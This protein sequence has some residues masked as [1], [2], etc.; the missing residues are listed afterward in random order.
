M[1]INT[2]D[3]AGSDV[4][5]GVFGMHTDDLG[6]TWTEPQEITAELDSGEVLKFPEPVVFTIA[7]L[8]QY[9]GGAVITTDAQPDDGMLELIVAQ[10]QDIPVLLANIHR[11]LSGSI[12]ELPRVVYRRFRS[13][14][15]IRTNEAPIQIDGDLVTAPRALPVRV[16]PRCLNVLVPR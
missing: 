11:L 7:N 9:G 15:A 1:T 14:N 10:K 5:K 4:F 8:T 2:L 6:E 16:A 12:S 3:V 13:L